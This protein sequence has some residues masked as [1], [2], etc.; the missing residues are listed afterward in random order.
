[1][2]GRGMSV[3]HVSFYIHFCA[4]FRLPGLFLFSF[5]SQL[6]RPLAVL[7]K[8]VCVLGFRGLRI[9]WTGLAGQVPLKPLTPGLQETTPAAKVLLPHAKL[10]LC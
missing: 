7:L 4:M 10:S 6:W 8:M 3:V 5:P 1:M 9:S 2:R